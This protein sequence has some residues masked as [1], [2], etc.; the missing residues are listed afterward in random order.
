MNYIK[1]WQD[2]SRTAEDD[3]YSLPED[4]Q[5][6]FNIKSIADSVNGDGLKSYYLSYAGAFAEDAANQLYDIGLD[7]VA[8]VIENANSLFP[9]GTPPEDDIERKEI[10]DEWDGDYDYLYDDWNETILQ[11][12]PELE[13]EIDSLFEKISNE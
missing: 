1:L 10:I 9:E 13:A 6:L 7:L 3:Y 4:R 5:T 11:N 8:A 2:I 12:I